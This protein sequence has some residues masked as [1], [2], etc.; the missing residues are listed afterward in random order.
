[1]HLTTRELAS[2]LAGLRS[3]QG[4]RSRSEL[5]AITTDGGQLTPL[6]ETEIDDLCDR[7]NDA[8][9]EVRPTAAQLLGNVPPEST[10]DYDP[11]TCASL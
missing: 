11:D 6:S 10:V 9:G 5:E 7:L 8:S 4:A 2:V 3:L 1:M